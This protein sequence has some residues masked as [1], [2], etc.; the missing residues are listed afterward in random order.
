MILPLA[1]Q[2][3]QHGRFPHHAWDLALRTFPITLGGFRRSS[4]HCVGQPAQK[5]Q[6][7]RGRHGLLEE[8]V[9]VQLLRVLHVPGCKEKRERPHRVQDRGRLRLGDSLLSKSPNRL[10][11]VGIALRVVMPPRSQDAQLHEGLAQQVDPAADRL[12]VVRALPQ[13]QAHFA[14]GE[15][16][17][18]PA[19][20]RWPDR[21][22]AR[23]PPPQRWACCSA[24][25]RAHSAATKWP[26]TRTA[27]SKASKAKPKSES[28]IS[29]CFCRK[30]RTLTSWTGGCLVFFFF[31]QHPPDGEG[32]SQAGEDSLL[33]EGTARP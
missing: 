13:P 28:C 8:G 29:P 4:C 6:R 32:T 24:R 11:P 27:S 20:G 17:C 30:A 7:S 1:L 33:T 10:L 22:P 15:P 3:E 18:R 21:R 26:P 19:E 12:G 25:T 5:L 2:G 9:K 16:H 23:D 31:L 14:C